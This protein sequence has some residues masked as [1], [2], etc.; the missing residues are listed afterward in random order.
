MMKRGRQLAAVRA[1]NLRR[2]EPEVRNAG[3]KYCG[4]KTRARK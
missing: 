3:S 2:K 4:R 1:R